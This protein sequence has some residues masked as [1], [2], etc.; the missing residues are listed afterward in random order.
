MTESINVKNVLIT[1]FGHVSLHS[2]VIFVL[3]FNGL[4]FC[5]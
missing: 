3:V 4:N 5:Y 1:V 2:H